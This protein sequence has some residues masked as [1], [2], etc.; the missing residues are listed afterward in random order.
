MTRANWDI[1]CQFGQLVPFRV[2]NRDK[3]RMLVATKG[4]RAGV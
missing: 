4:S 1:M 2:A 3:G